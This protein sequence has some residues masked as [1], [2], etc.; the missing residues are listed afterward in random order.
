MITHTYLWNYVTNK[1]LTLVISFITLYRYLIGQN[2]DQDIRYYCKNINKINSLI[3]ITIV[4][5]WIISSLILGFAFKG[6][7]LNTFFIIKSTPVV[8]TL[9]DIRKNKHLLINGQLDYLP[10][11]ARINKF[12]I[13]DIITRMKETKNI[14]NTIEKIINGEGIIISD[15]LNTKKFI[16]SAKF[17]NDKISVSESKYLPDYLSFIVHKNRNFTKIIEFW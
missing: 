1:T 6:L 3:F 4:I 5:I 14:T 2:Q 17:Y 11:L 10:Y 8:N 16:S 13:E 15:S 7:L 9:E 12:T